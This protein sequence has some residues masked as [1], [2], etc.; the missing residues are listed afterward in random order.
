MLGGI[1]ITEATRRYAVE[2]LQNASAAGTP[3][4]KEKGK[5]AAGPS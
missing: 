3:A 4:R 2:M 1:N 5:A